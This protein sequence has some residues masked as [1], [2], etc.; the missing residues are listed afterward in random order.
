MD[1]RLVAGY[2]HQVAGNLAGHGDAFHG[3]R[4]GCSKNS[5]GAGAQALNN[6]CQP[7]AAVTAIGKRSPSRNHRQRPLMLQP[8]VNRRHCSCPNSVNDRFWI[9]GVHSWTSHWG[10]ERTIVDTERNVCIWRSAEGR[11]RLD[12]IQKLEDRLGDFMGALLLKPMAS[13]R[14]DM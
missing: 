13:F 9:R 5:N 14:N 3:S 6:G 2:Q 12:V 8:I 1:G 10:R 4:R 11:L 7:M